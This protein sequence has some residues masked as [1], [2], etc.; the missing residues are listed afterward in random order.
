MNNE[1]EDTN[2]TLSE[3]RKSKE[4]LET[5]VSSIA[6][7]WVSEDTQT[8]VESP[9]KETKK[10]KTKTKR[11]PKKKVKSEPEPEPEP[12]D[13]VVKEETKM[14]SETK[15][16][17]GGAEDEEGFIVSHKGVE[18]VVF[19]DNFDVIRADD[20]EEDVIGRWDPANKVIIFN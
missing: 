6:S 12:E 11:L 19:P 18:Y 7:K 13:E 16:D 9:S 4:S 8:Q 10:T 15:D 1:L 17:K 5:L 14:E 20:K 3:L 2:K